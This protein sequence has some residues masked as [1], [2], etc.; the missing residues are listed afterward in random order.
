VETIPEGIGLTNQLDELLLGLPDATFA[1]NLRA[2]YQ[3]AADGIAHLGALDVVGYESNTTESSADLSL[4][5]EMAP[6][7]RD[8]VEHVNQLVAIIQERFRGGTAPSGS[9]PDARKAQRVEQALRLGA[10]DLRRGVT[11]LGEHM[12]SPSVVSD[13]WNLLTEIQSFR[14]RF[15]EQLGDLVYETAELLAPVTREQ[16]VPGLSDDVQTAAAVRSTV[17]DLRRVLSARVQKVREADEEDAQWNA[18]QFEKELDFFGK[19]PAYRWLPV[20]DKRQVVEQRATLARLSSHSSASKDELL[21]VAEALLALVEDASTRPHPILEEHDRQTWAA[22]GVALE[23]ATMILDTDPKGAA[24]VIGDAVMVAQ[25]LYGRSTSMDAFLRRLKKSPPAQARVHE[26][27]A[28]LEEFREVLAGF[29][30]V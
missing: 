17:A 10:E 12:R 15:R 28:L 22:V 25:A 27:P 26:L 6:M 23:Q 19:T 4:W 3:A 30:L 13:R 16:V 21:A 2:V 8:T 29:A 9:D 1:T 7:L 20:P 24:Q 11:E 5:E 14:D 18:Q